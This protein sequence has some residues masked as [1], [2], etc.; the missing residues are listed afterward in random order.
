MDFWLILHWVFTLNVWF[1]NAVNFYRFSH[2]HF[3]NRTKWIDHISLLNHSPA[4]SEGKFSETRSNTWKR[5]KYISDAFFRSKTNRRQRYSL[6][7]YVLLDLVE[8]VLFCFVLF[9]LEFRTRTVIEIVADCRLLY[10]V[11][12]NQTNFS[13]LCNFED[14]SGYFGKRMEQKEFFCGLATM[15]LCM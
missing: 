9:L 15:P 14:W 12:I 3:D 13:V 1:A 7:S 10:M 5:I 6:F 2:V 11:S 4:D 8:L